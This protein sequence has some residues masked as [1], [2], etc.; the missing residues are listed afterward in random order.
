MSFVTSKADF[1]LWPANDISIIIS[2]FIRF[3][4]G[5]SLSFS[6]FA[7]TEALLL[8]LL[9]YQATLAGYADYFSQNFLKPFTLFS[10]RSC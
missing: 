9:A 2:R 7:G 3:L 5:A 10:V 4:R 8:V 6:L 1:E